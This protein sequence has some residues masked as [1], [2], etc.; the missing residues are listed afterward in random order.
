[1]KNWRGRSTAKSM[2]CIL[3]DLQRSIRPCWLLLGVTSYC[4][5]CKLWF[6]VLHG[7][8]L[9]ILSGWRSSPV[10]LVLLMTIGKASLSVG[11]LFLHG[12]T[13]WTRSVTSCRRKHILKIISYRHFRYSK[14]QLLVPPPQKGEGA[15]WVCQQQLYRYT[16]VRFEHRAQDSNENKLSG[17]LTPGCSYR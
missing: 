11:W 1:M 7:V 17:N 4:K 15:G 16:W 3:L 10:Q 5:S 8:I 2:R 12:C 14:C 9:V 6:A 13:L